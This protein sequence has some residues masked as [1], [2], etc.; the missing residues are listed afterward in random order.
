MLS[1]E[2]PPATSSKGS[3]ACPVR[4]QAGPSGTK[5]PM[6]SRAPPYGSDNTQATI[7]KL[8]ALMRF[9]AVMRSKHTLAHAR[10]VSGL[11]EQAETAF[12]IGASIGIQKR[13]GLDEA[14]PHGGM[15]SGLRSACC[16]SWAFPP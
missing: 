10:A 3:P 5:R 15:A 13:N 4:K 16:P 6:W 14:A 1:E 9:C 8:R 7:A 2:G 11:L 12:Q